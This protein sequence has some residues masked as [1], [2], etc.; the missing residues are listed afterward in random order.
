MGGESAIPYLDVEQTRVGTGAF[1]HA[2]RTT[3][4]EPHSARWISRTEETMYEFSR[5]LEKISYRLSSKVLS[6]KGFV[7]A[8]I[9][10][11]GSGSYQPILPG[12][13]SDDSWYIHGVVTE[14][15][16]TTSHMCF[17]S[18]D[19]SDRSKHWIWHCRDNSSS[20]SHTQFRILCIAPDNLFMGSCTEDGDIQHDAT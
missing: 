1:T 17:C 9:I 12:N 14:G 3:F 2:A 8:S 6:A 4:G 20:P 13:A 5:G 7:V 16:E 19:R 10:I 11:F 15:F 18:T